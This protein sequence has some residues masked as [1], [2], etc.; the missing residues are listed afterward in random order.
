MTEDRNSAE[1]ALDV[2]LYA[3]VGLLLELCD[4]MPELAEK[5][6]E[7]LGDQ[8][9]AARLIGEMAVKAGKRKLDEV[10]AGLREADSDSSGEALAGSTEPTQSA[11]DEATK[12]AGQAQGA[13][14]GG[15]PFSGYDTMTAAEII[16]AL[17]DLPS[18]ERAV[19]KAYG[20]AEKGR[21]TIVGKLDQM[22]A[23]EQDAN[24]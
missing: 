6:R 16:R 12:S 7:R 19:I 24:G 10:V 15:E 1:Q 5:G 9:P 23:R 17:A 22:D 13:T 8:A 2:L 21:R 18:A 11:T 4:R 3:P 14:I 20:L